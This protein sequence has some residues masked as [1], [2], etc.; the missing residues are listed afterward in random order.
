MGIKICVKGGCGSDLDGYVTTIKI[1]DKIDTREC[2]NAVACH[3][4]TTGGLPHMGDSDIEIEN[5]PE[6]GTDSKTWSDNIEE[7]RRDAAVTFYLPVYIAHELGHDAGLMHHPSGRH[8]MLVPN[9]VIGA[10]EP[11]KTPIPTLSDL[12]SQDDKDA[13]ESIYRHHAAHQ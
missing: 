4:P 7:A 8:L 10:D 6:E 13:M 5:P 12:M 9:S 2:R 11:G 1:V 3:I